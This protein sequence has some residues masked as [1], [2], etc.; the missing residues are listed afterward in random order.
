MNYK[1]KLRAH[2]KKTAD[3]ISEKIAELSVNAG[4]T[5]LPKGV[6]K[7]I[8]ALKCSLRKAPDYDPKRHE[9]EWDPRRKIEDAEGGFEI[10]KSR[11]NRHSGRS[12][13]VV[14]EA[15]DIVTRTMRHFG[16]ITEIRK[17]MERKL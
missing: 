9:R 7:A 12:Y 11:L 4:Y 3:E 5:E 15:G 16:A 2:G 1:K 10:W 17:A 8:C 14:D 6:R 13:E